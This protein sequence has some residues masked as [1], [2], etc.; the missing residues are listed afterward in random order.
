[1]AIVRDSY[2]HEKLK[3]SCSALAFSLLDRRI[4]ELG[5]SAGSL[6]PPVSYF[7]GLSGRGAFV[8]KAESQEH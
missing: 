3:V 1:M 8:S 4:F 5:M 2:L 7:S 6:A